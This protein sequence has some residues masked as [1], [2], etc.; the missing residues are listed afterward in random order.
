M[1]YA[2]RFLSLLVV[3][4]VNTGV[5]SD[6]Q[7]TP[8]P[9]PVCV[10]TYSQPLVE[11][12]VRSFTKM[13]TQPVFHVVGVAN[14]Q[15][16]AGLA[17]DSQLALR[18][19]PL[20]VPDYHHLSK[21]FSG[22]AGMRTKVIGRY[23]VFVFVHEKNPV[24]QLNLEHLSKIFLGTIKDW[25]DL[26]RGDKG[27]PIQLFCPYY[28]SAAYHIVRDT[29][30]EGADLDPKL[31][32]WSAKPLRMKASPQAVLH[33]VSQDRNAIGFCLFS[34]QRKLPKEIQILG[35]LRKGTTEAVEPSEDTIA[36][37]VY[38]LYQEISVLLSPKAVEKT[39]GLYDFLLSSS[40][41]PSLQKH[42]VYPEC[43]R[44]KYLADKHL[45]QLKEGMGQRVELVGCSS[46][47]K[48]MRDVAL[49]Y[50][51]L[52]EPLKADFSSN[53]SPVAAVSGFVNREDAILILP[54]KV[55]PKTLRTCKDKWEELS[56][57]EYVLGGRAVAVITHAENPI[58]SLT[59]EQVRS[60]FTGRTRS[61]NDLAASP[62]E[63][64]TRK[65]KNEIHGYGLVGT[66][67]AGKLFSRMALS[68]MPTSRVRKSRT[69]AE[70]ISQVASDRQA[71]A[72]VDC[73]AL[74]HPGC[75][76]IA[77]GP[78]KQAVLL[79]P[80]TIANGTY[81]YAEQVYLYTPQNI[82]T[83]TE[84]LLAFML[85]PENVTDTLLQYGII[86]TER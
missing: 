19:G 48:M 49:E 69:A 3:V 80:K 72:F 55:D 60:I 37:G 71:I 66:S 62:S 79:T 85:K 84:K 20:S 4:L 57:N 38:P 2:S 56:P 17:K 81:P 26:P 51:K 29:L 30:L 23:V 41:V 77:I 18:R 86:P 43:V 45:K 28:T 47:K 68:A 46:E 16:T 5:F 65:G 31:K 75:K 54:Q 52:V 15:V 22:L 11:E 83:P 13:E 27:K 32:D 35:L 76:S 64:N 42:L 70:V 10:S 25:G 53:S 33:A 8:Q 73:T 58:S 61:W 6:K 9:I 82:S 63:G 39:R 21:A 40:C 36:E 14:N 50:V 59:N 34:L 1:K 67:P 44:R 74:P 24:R 78:G 7:K 12:L